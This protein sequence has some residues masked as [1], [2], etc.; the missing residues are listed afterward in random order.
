VGFR[1]AT[2]QVAREF[3]VAGYVKNLADGRVLLEMEGHPRDLAAFVEAVEARMHGYVRSTE[4]AVDRREPEFS[5][6]EIR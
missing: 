4:T 5:G 2:M 6:F 1:F 3:E